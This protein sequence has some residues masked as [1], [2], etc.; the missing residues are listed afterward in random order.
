MLTSVNNIRVALLA[1]QAKTRQRRLHFISNLS[2]KR[3]TKGEMMAPSHSCQRIL[4]CL[5]RCI[6]RFLCLLRF[7]CPICPLSDSPVSAVSSVPLLAMSSMGK[8]H[9]SQLHRAPLYIL[10]S[11]R[12]LQQTFVAM[13]RTFP[14]SVRVCF[15]SFRT[16]PALFLVSRAPCSWVCSAL[17]SDPS[18]S[19]ACCFVSHTRPCSW[20]CSFCLWNWSMF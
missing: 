7:H 12:S 8:R 3:S 20:V 1:K 13:F 14:T 6:R 5:S 11:G 18:C 19:W 2:N 10:P 17:F 15:L 9:S 16:A 4:R